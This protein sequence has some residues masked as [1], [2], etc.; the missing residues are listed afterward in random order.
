MREPNFIKLCQ[1]LLLR[2]RDREMRAILLVVVVLVWTIV[3]PQLFKSFKC[4]TTTGGSRHKKS[5]S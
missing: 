2:H 3:R 4:T 5:L 1:P